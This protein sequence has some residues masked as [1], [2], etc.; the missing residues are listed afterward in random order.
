MSKTKKSDINIKLKEFI[1]KYSV[2]AYVA[3]GVP[4][5]FLAMLLTAQLK[6]ISNTEEVLQGKREAQLTDDL[7]TL[8]REYNELKEKYDQSSSVVKEYQT[9]ASSNDLLIKSMK[10]EIRNFVRNNRFVW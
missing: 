5:F 3:I 1:K 4:L 9:N 2:I 8:Q 6:S 10:E 7:V